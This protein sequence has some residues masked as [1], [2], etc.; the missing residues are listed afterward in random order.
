[1]ANRAVECVDVAEISDWF[2]HMDH[3]MGS[4]KV[5]YT[6]WGFSL[7]FFVERSSTLAHGLDIVRKKWSG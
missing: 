7:L 6:C 3:M 1:M 4:K 5:L 2:I